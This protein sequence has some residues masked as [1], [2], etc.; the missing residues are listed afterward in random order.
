M[1]EAP[2]N[3]RRLADILA[4]LDTTETGLSRDE[5]KTR[6]AKNG[7]NA[8]KTAP[9]CERREDPPRAVQEP[10]FMGSRR[11]R[12]ARRVSR[13]VG[14]RHRDLRHRRAE[15]G[16]RVLPGVPRRDVDPVAPGNGRGQVARLARR[17]SGTNTDRRSGCWRRAGS[18]GGRSGRRRRPV[19][20]RFVAEA[21]S[22]P[23]WTG[24]SDAADKTS[25]LLETV[26]VPL[27]ERENMVFLGTSVASGTGHAVVV[28]TAMDTELG[29]IAEMIEERA[30]NPCDAAPE[31]AR[32]VRARAGSS[33]RWA[34]SSF[35]F[36]SASGAA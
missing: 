26:E 24:E 29:Q 10:D 32:R 5:A 13:R 31:K 22:K 20:L 12:G 19:V 3:E 30:G 6:L 36:C 27:A 17:P 2:W 16:D 21:A 8:L 7:P 1:S 15:R 11:R 4:T 18:R 28:A 35:Y 33:R 34:S 25:H 14:G 9:R 23:R